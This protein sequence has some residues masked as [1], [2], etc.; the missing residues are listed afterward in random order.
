MSSALE[1][2]AAVD[3]DADAI[4][5]GFARACGKDP[6]LVRERVRWALTGNPAGWTG[7]VAVHGGAGIVAH[8]GASHVPMLVEGRPETFGR[9]FASWVAPEYRIAGVHSLFCRMDD[10]FDAAAR[11]TGLAAVFC[12]LAEGDWW[13]L[14][15][16]RG[17]EGVRTELLLAR[18]PRSHAPRA[19]GLPV[20]RF[21]PENAA[22]LGQGPALGPCHARRDAQSV[23]FRTGGP[24]RAD[25]AWTCVRD[26]RAA[27]LAIVRDAGGRRT[28]LDF[29][30]PEGDEEAAAALLDCAIG[31]GS[32][33][34]LLP[35]F[36]RSPW[37]LAA[38]RAGFRAMPC[39]LP[40]VGVRPTAARLV[41]TWLMQHWHLAAADV[42]LRPPPRML[43][44][45]EA[46]TTAPEGT[47]T[48]KDRKS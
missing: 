8:L 44:D 11:A 30:V 25:G 43:A 9:L 45:E 5:A 1:I 35:W 39:D 15:R 34:V 26:G 22:T 12:A 41:A 3:A 29:A 38:Q 47:L 6:P 20:V 37:F 33:E 27:G 21:G 7:V 46:V 16:L 23:L 36:S 2:R 48:A 4:A 17:F 42:G 14:R 10:A 13:T 28:V 24:Y 32:R 19:A 18:A 31:D 40:T